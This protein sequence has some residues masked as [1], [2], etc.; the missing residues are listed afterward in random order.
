MDFLGE[1]FPKRK[2][3]ALGRGKARKHV[4]FRAK[5]SG[6]KRKIVR[7]IGYPLRAINAAA[8]R[9]IEEWFGQ[10]SVPCAPGLG[11]HRQGAL[12]HHR[13]GGLGAVRGRQMSASTPTLMVR[14]R[15]QLERAV[16]HIRAEPGLV[17]F[18]LARPGS[19]QQ[20]LVDLG[21]ATLLGAVPGRCSTEPGLRDAPVPGRRR[22]PGPNGRHE[23]DQRQP[24]A[25][26]GLELHHPTPTAAESLDAERPR[27]GP[28]VTRR[29]QPPRRRRP[30]YL[31]IR[32][33]HRQRPLVRAAVP[34]ALLRD[35]RNR[36][37]DCRASPGQLVGARNPLPRTMG[38]VARLQAMSASS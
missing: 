29:R 32:G 7:G 34:G 23:V 5:L 4:G 22:D 30:V 1:S 15:R 31:A 12:K 6:G 13:Q 21:C 20:F 3:P 2:G 26:R 11:R 18:T 8:I 35:S 10:A 16:G 36:W 33:V 24:A 28:Q 37:S 9:G 25:H 27:R 14:S 19:A 17:F 38:G